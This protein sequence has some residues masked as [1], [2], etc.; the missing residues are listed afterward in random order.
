MKRPELLLEWVWFLLL[1]HIPDASFPSDHAIVS[2]WFITWLFL[3]WFKKIWIIFSIFTFLMLLSRI[4]LWV[5][6]PLDIIVWIVSWILWPIIIFIYFR[7]NK[8]VKKLNIFIIKLLM[9]IKL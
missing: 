2:S 9:Y 8:L 5:H 4:I 3:Y 7:E 6:W 1:N